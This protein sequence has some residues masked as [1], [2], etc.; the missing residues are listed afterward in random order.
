MNILILTPIDE[1][2]IF[3][4]GQDIFNT[5]GDNNDVFSVQMMAILASDEK[6]YPVTNEVFAAEARDN[7]RLAL[8]KL[9]SYDNLIVFGNLDC[10]TITFDHI[11]TCDS[12]WT[13]PTNKTDNYITESRSRFAE[14]FKSQNIKPIRYYAVEDAEFSFPTWA[15]LCLFLKTLGVKA[16]G[17]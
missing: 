12:F 14:T 15:H 7:P 9:K 2:T 13:D 4:V 10:K 6:N 16:N 1:F 8:N 5:Y 3:S 11:I 17:V